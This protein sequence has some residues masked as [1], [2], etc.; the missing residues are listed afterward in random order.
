MPVCVWRPFL[1][2]VCVAGSAG[3]RVVNWFSSWRL[4]STTH[5][6][7]RIY[8]LSGSERG[9]DLAARALSLIGRAPVPPPSSPPMGDEN[10]RS[11]AWRAPD[12]PW[13]VAKLLGGSIV[14]TIVHAQRP[15]LSIGCC[16]ICRT[17]NWA[18][19]RRWP[20]APCCPPFLL[21]ASYHWKEDM[22]QPPIM[23]I[24]QQKSE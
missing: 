17:Y 12:G 5:L 2:H 10:R 15:N 14:H 18:S 13:R 23:I 9:A 20:G 6:H 8:P 21:D 24:N 1:W 4:E 22:L 19:G 11:V 7:R 3:P 16:A